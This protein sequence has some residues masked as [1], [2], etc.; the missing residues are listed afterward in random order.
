M[1]TLRSTE[2]FFPS[3]LWRFELT[4]DER[5]TVNR[6]ALSVLEKLIGGPPNLERGQHW[7]TDGALHLVPEMEL[8]VRA[9][10]QAASQVLD[11]LDVAYDQA[12]ITGCWANINAV[13]ANHHEH[14]HPNNF[15]SGVYYVQADEGANSIS[16]IDPRPQRAVIRPRVTEST[17][18]NSSEF[19]LS[20]KPGDLLVFPAWLPHA[21][22]HN[23]STRERISISFNVMFD[24]FTDTMS[25]PEWTGRLS[26]ES[27]R[28]PGGSESN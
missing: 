9:I 23:N 15:L 3:F 2:M 25:P 19:G 22:G 26:T 28:D 7:E 18:F 16:I 10:G 4:P 8:L 5:D 11:F 20:V 1:V 17:P 12:R 14:T 6:N 24:D 21:V 27:L 13:H